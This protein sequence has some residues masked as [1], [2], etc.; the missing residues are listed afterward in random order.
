MCAP[1]LILSSF[2]TSF[3]VVSSAFALNWNDAG[4]V[5]VQSI[6][7]H[8]WRDAVTGQFINVA[9]MPGISTSPTAPSANTNVSSSGNNTNTGTNT[10]TN[11]N[12]A[13][14]TP[15]NNQSTGRTN[16]GGIKTNWSNMTKT[17]RAGAALGVVGGAAGIYAATTGQ[18]EHSG[19]NVAGGTLSGAA[20]G[21]SVGSIFPGIGTA[22]GAGVGALVGGLI[23]GSQLF[24]ETDC[25][26]DPITGQFT[27]CNTVF[28]KGERQA[29][30]GD[31]MF[32]GIE[33]EDGTN[34]AL[35][36]GVRQCLQGSM[37][38][39]D[40]WS[41]TEASWWKGLSK[42]DFW[43][44]ECTPRMCSSFETPTAGIEAYINYIPDPEN[45]CWKWEC[46][47]GY[48]RSGNTCV[49]SNGS[50]AVN[51]YTTPE[52]PNANPYDVLI[53]RLQYQRDNIIQRCGYVVNGKGGNL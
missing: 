23:S 49:T 8:R 2:L 30:I 9:G 13:T 5:P 32:C 39:K 18:E 17:A 47:D 12:S 25:L 41:D 22:I 43:Q 27:C 52:S 7:D 10:G 51:P 42:D 50:A 44:P 28:N 38:D 53:Q 37:S 1:K 24:S 34:K 14:N 6:S 31:Y 4:V 33:Q 35:P 45:Y 15:P 40:T 16:S 21:A 46:V 20:M 29:K 26:Y 36:P 3:I 11:T 48:K 19:W